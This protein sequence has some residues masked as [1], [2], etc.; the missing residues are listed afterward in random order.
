[1]ANG[2]ADGTSSSNGRV[3]EASSPIIV[4]CPGKIE[5]L[6][7][8]TAEYV[9]QHNLDPA[10]VYKHHVA[11]SH[12]RWATHGIP[13]SVNSHPQVSDANAD[14]VIVHNG[15]ITNYQAL[16]DILVGVAAG[17]AAHAGTSSNYVCTFASGSSDSMA[18]AVDARLQASS[19]SRSSSGKSNI[20]RQ[21]SVGEC[22]LSCCKAHVHGS[23]Q[24]CCATSKERTG[25]CASLLLG[26]CQAAAPWTC[27]TFMHCV[28]L[29]ADI[30]TCL[31][32][33]MQSLPMLRLHTCSSVRVPPT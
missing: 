23:L 26:S 12:T 7:N 13:S 11:I 21:Q 28:K 30:V 33:Y 32:N 6:E 8:L 5:N 27:Y 31:G 22:Q 4:K 18:A 10:K 16:K 24:D 20:C 9:Q 17:G 3:E 25:S 19:R 15:I 2:S 14:F 1:M 29:A